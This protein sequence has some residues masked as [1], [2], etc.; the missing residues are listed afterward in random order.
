MV[1][2]ADVGLR[3][4]LEVRDDEM[5]YVHTGHL[6]AGRNIPLILEAFSASPHHVLFLGDGPMKAD[7]LAARESCAY[8]HWM[9]PVDPDL[10][11]AH[12]REA[13]VGLCLIEEKLD[14]SDRLSSPNKLMEALAAD[15]PALC[16]DLIE[17]RRLL[18]SLA[19]T[20]VLGDIRDLPEALKRIEKADVAEFR[21][22]WSGVPDWSA[23]VQPLVDAYRTMVA[24]PH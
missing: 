6:V 4:I 10:I 5:L 1:K 13:D 2:D 20:W 11:V 9:A 12:M 3:K 24:T 23:E 16:T 14:L 15:T 22:T 21:A 19:E 18:G 7:V 17:A 8:I